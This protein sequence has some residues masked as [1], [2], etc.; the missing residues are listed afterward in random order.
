[1]NRFRPFVSTPLHSYLVT[2]PVFFA[3]V[4]LSLAQPTIAGWRLHHGWAAVVGASVMLLASPGSP[5]TLVGAAM[6]VLLK[7]VIIIISLM[8][9]TL[10]A[11]Q[12]GLF[13]RVLQGILRLAR[14]DGRRLFFWL[15]WGGA[16]TG[17]LFTNDAAVLIFTPLVCLMLRTLP[18]LSPLPFLFA[19]LNIA[20]LVAVLV[21]SN[22]I[23]IVVAHYFGID[24]V[25]YAAWMA[26]PALS[27]AVSTYLMLR[28]YF[29]RDISASRLPEVADVPEP[30]SPFARWCVGVIAVCVVAAFLGPRVGLPLWATMST[31]ACLLLFTGRMTAGID[32]LEVVK[33][34]AWDVLVFVIGFFI[35]VSGLKSA[36]ISGH[37]GAIIDRLAG[38]DPIGLVFSTGAVAALSSALMNN[39]PTAYLMALTINDMRPPPPLQHAL[40]FAQLIGG[41]LGPKML[42]IGSLAAL[43]WFRILRDHDIHV[44][45]GLYVKIGVPVT[46]IALLLALS[47]LA[48]QLYV[49]T[50]GMLSVPS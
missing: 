49:A 19:V 26:L 29:H 24:F 34:V 4:Y 44:P 31:G 36:G 28:W 47:I 12:A 48:V 8:V 3:T 21:I 40:A 45:Y 42:P 20:N 33:G 41:D 27:A 50:D 37:L 25:D 46:L 32:P 5:W 11:R 35:L 14:G 43:L 30:L 15:F 9:M 17:A 1:V 18:G 7:P 23:N 22:P 6:A 2:L 16:V 38:N 13:D 10:V 39:H